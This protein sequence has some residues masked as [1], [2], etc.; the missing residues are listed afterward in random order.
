MT[1]SIHHRYD[2]LFAEAEGPVILAECPCAMPPGGKNPFVFSFS[3]GFGKLAHGHFY[4]EQRQ[5]G[6]T[7]FHKTGCMN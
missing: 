5:D 3:L 2:W 4:K 1:A 6:G 7:V